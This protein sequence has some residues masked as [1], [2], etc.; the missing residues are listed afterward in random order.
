[1]PSPKAVHL[2][3]SQS[4]LVAQLQQWML[5]HICWHY[6]QTSS[7]LEGLQSL[8]EAEPLF[9]QAFALQVVEGNCLLSPG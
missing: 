8:P 5:D 4:Q 7:S 1:M 9:A 2:I 6:K 3:F